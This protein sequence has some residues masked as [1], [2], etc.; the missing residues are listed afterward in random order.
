MLGEIAESVGSR[1]QR[2][3]ATILDV[4]QVMTFGKVGS[5][6]REDELDP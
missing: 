1:E 3:Q 2:R 5:R 4:V 6:G